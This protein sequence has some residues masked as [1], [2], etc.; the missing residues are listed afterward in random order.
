M[1]L[2]VEPGGVDVASGAT[3]ER[4][5]VDRWIDDEVRVREAQATL[6]VAGA[7]QLPYELV[8]QPGM[9]AVRTRQGLKTAVEVS[10]EILATLRQ[11]AE[12][13][14][15]DELF[16]AVI[17]VPAYFDDA[18]R[19]ATKDAARLAGLN[20]LRLLNEPTAAAI[21]YGLENASEGVYAV[22]DLGGGT[23][24]ISILRLSRGVFEVVSTNGDAALGG[25]DFDHRL[26]C[27]MLDNAGIS[28]PSDRD[29][30]RLQMKAR[31]VKERLTLDESVQVSMKLEG[32]DDVDLTIT[33]E[34]FIAMTLPLVTKTLAPVR[35]A[36]RDAGLGAEDVKGVVMVG[37]FSEPWAT[38]SPASWPWQSPVRNPHRRGG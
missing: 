36:L 14:F 18:Q 28:L 15:D 5:L 27:W 3:E 34:A 17:T 1:R 7:A 4:A 35:K 29:A 19:Q 21:A 8:D 37:S 2:A 11:R 38:S 26:F 33:R 13:S 23:F 32:G 9:V 12:D 30:R 20:V 6:D 25:D 31:E 24:D 22:Y 16:G 10:A